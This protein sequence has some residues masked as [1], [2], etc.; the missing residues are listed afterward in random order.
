MKN[1]KHFYI[2]FSAFI[3]LAAGSTVLKAQSFETIRK[4]FPDEKAVMLNRTL[5]YNI[6]LKNG[7]PNVESHE[8][9]QI[10]YLLGT[11]AAFMGKYGFSHS[12][13]Q[14]LV[15][16][17]AYTLTPD[18]KKLKVSE[19]K[20]GTDKESFVFYD[21]VKETSF[22]FPAVEPGAIGNL[23]VSWNNTDPHLL[24]PFYFTD[25]MPVVN[26]ELKITVSKDISLKYHLVGQDTSN[27]SV[28]V[29]SKHH[30]NIYTFQYKNC[31][32]DKRYPDAPGFAWYS[33]HILFYIANYKDDKG[34][35]VP[36]LSNA[37][38]LYRLNYSYIKSVNQ[39]ISPELK[40]IVDSLTTGLTNAELKA[41]SIY[42]WV[43]H[44]IKYVA[45]EDGMGGFVPREASLVCSRRF[46]DCKDMAS[47]LTE[48][49]NAA[50]VTAYFTW[51][52][53][54]D[55]PYKFSQ[56]PLPIVSN[57]MIC[58]INLDG[59]Y[60]F[61]DGTDPTCVFGLT[62]AGIQDKEAMIA[63]NDKEYKILKVPVI[64]KSKNVIADTTWLELTPTGIKGKIRKTL[65]GYPAMEMYGNLMYWS[66]RNIKE[67]MKNE[68]S[69]GSNKFQLDTFSVEK[70]P[71]WDQIALTGEFILPDYAKK[72]GNDYYL[73][74]NL[75][76]FF[77]H[78]EIDYP[79]RKV[80]VESNFKS[81][82]K[83]VTLLKVPD[84]Y[85]VS[86]LPQ[87]KSYHNKVWGFDLKYE[88]KGNWVVLT[89]EFDN[90]DLTLTSDEFEAWNKVLQ[91]LF[92]L[93]KETLSL[94]KN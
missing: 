3:G 27:V 52:G 39:N 34:N 88:Q 17:D 63:L 92:P 23:E 94:T 35:T 20:T 91:N 67:D 90:N 24:S 81:V 64:D 8:Q 2:F 74:L 80:P 9:Q 12:D 33:P 13:F 78:E 84:G 45:F 18:N 16:Y 58:T 46:G 75:F 86:Y 57:H 32:A 19:F 51:I 89:Q 71:V 73:N 47:I 79:K 7:Q 5:E 55:L 82:K 29:E 42:K 70:K 10:E 83:Y 65:S 50:G 43:Q 72:I 48:M 36:Y 54:R 28:N 25:Y 4:Q 22:N 60:V 56:V 69:R 38:D 15:S 14:Q 41:R 62:P 31:P 37:D 68:L 40:H 87:G 6:D 59:K 26:S 85:G 21:D 66:S 11:A 76:K 61:L 44:N 30:N 1:K 53:T 49:N 93:Y 77:E